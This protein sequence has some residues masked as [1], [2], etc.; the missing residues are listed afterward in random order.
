MS[1]LKFPENILLDRPVIRFQTRDLTQNYSISLPCPGSISFNDG[2][3]F[4]EISLGL[5]GEGEKAMKGDLSGIKDM[6][7]SQAAEVLGK[8]VIKSDVSNFAMKSITN[9]NTNL[10]FSGNTVRTFAFNFRMI[11]TSARDSN[12]I[13]DIHSTFRK[14]T[15]ADREDGS[16]TVTL[17]F[18]PTWNIKFIDGFNGSENKY[19][20]KIFPCYLTSVESTFN[21]D[22]NLFF[23][24][25]APLQV[26]I[27]LQFQEARALTRRDIE[28][29]E[30]GKV[31][32]LSL[33]G[34]DD[35]DDLASQSSNRIKQQI[36]EQS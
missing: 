3:Q 20:P 18:P 16:S 29:L 32:T 17:D 31:D 7:A 13:K 14:Y 9:P 28:A 35:D 11:A 10:T 5:I 23:T 36:P 2:A 4:N 19:L 27:A 33:V 30:A 24:D 26:D 8:A 15:Y 12:T 21:S 22:A 1:N 6:A 25:N 34:T